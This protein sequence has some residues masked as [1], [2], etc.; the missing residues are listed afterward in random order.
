MG[1]H[2]K[3]GARAEKKVMELVGPILPRFRFT[4]ALTPM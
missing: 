4:S 2:G 3:I 1:F